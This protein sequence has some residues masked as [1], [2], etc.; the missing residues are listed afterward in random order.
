MHQDSSWKPARADRPRVG[1]VGAGRLG[2][3]LAAAL[4]QAGWDVDAPAARREVPAADAVILCVPDAEIPRA[5]AALAGRAR[6]VGH[7]SGATPIAALEPAGAER[8]G[9]HPLQSFPGGPADHERFDGAGCAIAGDTPGALDLAREL[10]HS[11]GMR[12]FELADE[13]RPAYHAAASISSNFLVTL[14]SAAE[15]VAGSA[16]IDPPAARGLLAPLVRATVDSWAELGPEQALTGPVKRGD[17]LTLAAQR[18][19]VRKAD[20]ALLPLFDALVEETRRLAGRPGRR[21]SA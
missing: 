9:L 8:F 15:R 2:T 14:E 16:G 12:P 11:L 13:Q 7:T 10:A 17:E 18:A 5:A 19:A 21:E 3:A 4:R 1:I 6:W 20:P